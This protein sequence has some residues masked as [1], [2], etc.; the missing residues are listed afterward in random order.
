MAQGA[1]RRRRRRREATTVTDE[2]MEFP[3]EPEPVDEWKVAQAAVVETIN[4]VM[5]AWDSTQLR[6]WEAGK[7]LHVAR[8]AAPHGKWLPFLDCMGI[9]R[10]T[11]FAWIKFF[12]RYP[13]YADVRNHRTIQVAMKA[14]R[15]KAVKKMVVPGKQEELEMS[16][17]ETFQPKAEKKKRKAGGGGTGKSR[18]S[19][20]EFEAFKTKCRKMTRDHLIRDLWKAVREVN[21]LQDEN[22]ELHRQLEDADLDDDPMETPP[23]LLPF[24]RSEDG[25]DLLQE[26][27]TP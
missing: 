21:R 4:R 7:A 14:V 16:R 10:S 22:E 9:A 12:E 5:T 1:Y 11:A 3:S 19:D 13:D 8:K 18:A 26:E 24:Y 27:D 2:R 25:A 20:P 15:E 6:A 23:R 17:F